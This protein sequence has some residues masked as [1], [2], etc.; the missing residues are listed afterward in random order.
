MLF[1]CRQF[2]IECSPE[3]CY[4]AVTL[5]NRVTG[6]SVNSAHTSI[7][8][9][10]TAGGIL[11]GQTP[12]YSLILR[13]TNAVFSVSLCVAICLNVTPVFKEDLHYLISVF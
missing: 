6:D 13:E 5:R 9:L 4:C 3:E 11:S 1:A 2:L 12:R 7:N 10:L 8:I